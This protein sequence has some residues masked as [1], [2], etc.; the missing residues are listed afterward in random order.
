MSEI[1]E[2]LTTDERLKE[3]MHPFDSQINEALNTS[4]GKYAP[5]GRTYCTSMSLAN[6]VLIAMGT[7]NLGYL[8][9]WTRVFESLQLDMSPSP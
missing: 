3:C 8:Q 9:Y 4:V 6:R 5:K 7:H 1:W 2:K